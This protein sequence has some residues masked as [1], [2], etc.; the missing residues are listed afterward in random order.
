[1]VTNG[2]LNVLVWASGIDPTGVNVPPD[3]TIYGTAARTL[4]FGH[5]ASNTEVWTVKICST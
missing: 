3:I 1:M 4:K 5:L 2:D